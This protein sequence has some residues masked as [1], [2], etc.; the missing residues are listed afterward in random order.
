MD[1]SEIDL[2]KFEKYSLRQP[3]VER[4]YDA[5]E[6]IE[7]RLSP[8]GLDIITK[9]ALVQ[10]QQDQKDKLRLYFWALA[11]RSVVASTWKLRSIDGRDVAQ[12]LYADYADTVIESYDRSKKMQFRSYARTWILLNM[13]TVVDRLRSV[14]NVP[15]QV[16][17]STRRMRRNLNGQ[18]VGE[19]NSKELREAMNAGLA[20]KLS[21]RHVDNV[22]HS[23]R[24]RV[25]Y[26]SDPVGDD[27]QVL[28]DIIALPKEE[29]PVEVA[30]AWDVV[31]SRLSM[32]TAKERNILRMRFMKGK[33]LATV[34][35]KYRQSGEYIRQ[36]QEDA[37]EKLRESLEAKVEEFAVA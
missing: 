15:H 23:Q 5:L 4:I 33:T 30:D 31:H 13:T 25:K 6:G 29:N 3:E 37:L 27:E 10:T 14:I 9:N 2:R 18:K 24:M 20:H 17:Q 12:Q 7:A 11:Y 8:S 16:Q 28:G 26:L 32:L 21:N 19:M 34:G 36:Q 35:S 1:K 22:L